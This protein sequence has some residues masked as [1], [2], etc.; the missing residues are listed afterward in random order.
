MSSS[1]VGGRWGPS[2]YQKLCAE[3]RPEPL[4]GIGLTVEEQVR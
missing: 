1:I 2:L 3:V 4:Q